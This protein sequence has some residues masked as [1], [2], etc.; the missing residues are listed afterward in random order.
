MS[1]EAGKLKTLTIKGK[2]GG[3]TEIGYKDYVKYFFGKR[4]KYF[5]EVLNL[6]VFFAS[7]N[8]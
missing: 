5:S 3:E 2:P 4:I 8:V 7:S 6:G 1:W